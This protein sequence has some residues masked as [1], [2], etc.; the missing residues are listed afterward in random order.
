MN[1]DE[2]RAWRAHVANHPDL[3]TAQRHILQTLEMF[4][5]YPHGTNAHPGVENLARASGLQT[6]AVDNTLAKARKLMLIEQTA[7][8]NP[9]LGLASVYRLLAVPHST[10]TL[11]RTES[12]STRTGVRIE[13][14]FNPHETRFQH[15]PP[16]VPP[17]H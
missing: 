9:K 4:A 2:R 6:R 15:A 5:D 14:D 17:D 7:R 16:C 12:N 13:D 11:V 3:T 8:A 10:R 1:A